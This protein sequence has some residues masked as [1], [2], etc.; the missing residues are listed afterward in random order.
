MTWKERWR[1]N[2]E[3]ILKAEKMKEMKVG[4]KKRILFD[5]SW[6]D[7]VEVEVAEFFRS[8]FIEC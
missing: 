8:L 4:C 1:A 7:E 3:E 2:D 6:W 5:I